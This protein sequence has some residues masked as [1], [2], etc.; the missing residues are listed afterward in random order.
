MKEMA[1]K[2]KDKTKLKVRVASNGPQLPPAPA[3]ANPVW[4][5]LTGWAAAT[6]HSP[7]LP[8]P[9]WSKLHVTNLWKKNYP[10]VTW[11]D[12]QIYNIFRR[13]IVQLD[14]WIHINKCSQYSG[15]VNE[16]KREEQGKV[17]FVTKSIFVTATKEFNMATSSCVGCSLY[18]APSIG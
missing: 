7:F 4:P 12:K 8:Q 3:L 5:L 17:T 1:G 2:L 14:P 6:R 10:L 13:I 18:L 9:P 15:K 16:I 11:A